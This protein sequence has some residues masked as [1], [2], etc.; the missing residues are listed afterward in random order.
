MS[1]FKKWLFII[2][3]F[4]VVLVFISTLNI[5]FENF[6]NENEKYNK[7]IVLIGD[8]ILNNSVY[9]FEN[10]SVPELVQQ[11]IQKDKTN[12][13]FYNFAKDGSLISDCHNQIL[14]LKLNSTSINL[15]T[16]F[17]SAGG[18]N[19]LHSLI[20]TESFINNLF[21]EYL[22]LIDAIKNICPSANIVAL[23]LYYPLK[24]SLK[25]LYP[26]IKQWNQLLTD[27]SSK[28][29]YKLIKLDE[30]IISNEDI[31]YDVE[32]SL[33]GGKKIA[34]AIFTF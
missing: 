34:N 2:V 21:A 30:L 25:L 1:Y 8:S 6:S 19:I 32:P 18:N 23:N 26:L 20:K 15:G 9:V 13:K 16:I 28:K 33:T 22:Q 24:P 12:M 7:N 3:L 27:N 4:I 11:L 29:G 10:E 17:L 14:N 5:V 31:V